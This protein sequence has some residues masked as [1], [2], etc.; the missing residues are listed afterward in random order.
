MLWELLIQTI[1]GICSCASKIG[2]VGFEVRFQCCTFAGCPIDNILRI[3]IWIKYHPLLIWEMDLKSDN[4]RELLMHIESKEPPSS[5]TGRDI[6]TIKMQLNFIVILFS[7][8]K[9]PSIMAFE[10]I[11]VDVL[12]CFHRDTA[13]KIHVT[14][15]LQNCPVQ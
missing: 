13:F 11:F 14:L 8:R 3:V 15:I 10:N 1:P 2:G 12:G 4:C 7:K 6:S 5:L 9:S